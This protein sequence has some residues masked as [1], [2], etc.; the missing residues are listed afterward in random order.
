[1]AQVSEAPANVATPVPGSAGTG[2]VAAVVAPPLSPAAAAV[3]RA[4]PA[5]H[6]TRGPL[7]HALI[8]AALLVSALLMIFPFYWMVATAFKSNVESQAYPPTLFPNEWHPENFVNVLDQAPFGRYFFNTAFV[9]IW[10]VAGVLVVSSLAAYAFARMEFFGKNL[11]FMVFLAT[12]MIPAEATLIP[13]FVIV[14]KWLGWYNTYQAQ[15]VPFLGNVFAIFLLRQFFMGVPKEL[16]D[17]ALID[18]ASPFRFLWSVV[19]P[20]STPALITVGL[21]NF[22]AAWNAFL[23]PLLVTRS[24]DMRPIQFGLSVFSGEAGVRYADLMAASTLVVLPT[25]IVF[26]VAQRYFVEGIART[27]LKG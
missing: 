22:L 14:T 27:G 12:L 25:V 5:H 4:A 26:L 15:F 16:E 20:L 24:P 23:W 1:M 2:V 9:A 18:G 8:Q 13:N 11:V 3:G 7:A 10:W 6:A 17:A 19:V 21:L